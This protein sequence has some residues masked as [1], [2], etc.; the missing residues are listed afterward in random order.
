MMQLNEVAKAVYEF[1]EQA[2]HSLESVSRNV[3]EF[4]DHCNTLLQNLQPHLPGDDLKES[5]GNLIRENLVKN[6]LPR[7]FPTDFGTLRVHFTVTQ[8]STNGDSPAIPGQDS[9]TLPGKRPLADN[10]ESSQQ[11]KRAKMQ[12]PSGN[13][14]SST[15]SGHENFNDIGH[16]DQNGANNGD[17]L[18]N[19]PEHLLDPA[20]TLYGHWQNTRAHIQRG[21]TNVSLWDILYHG[22]K[23]SAILLSVEGA[24]LSW[25]QNHNSGR[26]GMSLRH[27]GAILEKASAKFYCCFRV[28]RGTSE[29]EAAKKAKA[30]EIR[31]QPTTKSTPDAPKY[32]F[33]ATTKRSKFENF[34]AQ[35]TA[36][37]VLASPISS[38]SRV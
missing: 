29:S 23:H 33:L 12:T 25:A 18:S 13:T 26:L 11:H 2:D 30:A 35:P 31:A 4:L 24:D 27:D 32:V 5:V 38:F 36:D 34:D 19:H 17:V 22:S 10:I 28:T 20:S 9:S 15:E 7:C 14:P 6:R 16:E 3:S 37:R 8:D 1:N 21:D